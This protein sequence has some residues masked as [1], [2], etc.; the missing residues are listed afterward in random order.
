M[1]CRA[2]ASPR[3]VVAGLLLGW[4]GLLAA[5]PAAADER[6][7]AYDIAIEV[8]ADG[9]LDV[10][11]QITVRAEGNRVRRGIY[12]DFPTRYRDR[13]GNRVVVG[14][15][16]LDVR[17]NGAPEPHFTES[18]ANGIR[19][20]TGNDSFLPVPA[21]YT[22]TLRYRTTRQLGFFRDHDELYWNAIGTGWIFPIDQGRVTV[23]LPTAVPVGEMRAEGYTGPQGAQGRAYTADLPEAGMAR[24]R[25]TSRLAP[26]EGLTI[27]LSF[28]KGIVAE[29]GRG[30]RFWWLLA[31]NRGL[32]VALAGFVGL[33]AF[34]V[35]RWRQVG[36]DPR[37]GVIIPR[38][39]PP[40]GHGPAGLRFVRRM[41]YD[42][43]CFSADVL[44]M[45]VAGHLRIHHDDG[46][47]SDGWGLERA[48]A[49]SSPPTDPGQRKLLEGLFPGGVTRIELRKANATTIS[50]ARRAHDSALEEAAQ[51]RYFRRNAGHVVIA[52]LI[53]VATAL[54]AFFLSGGAGIAAIIV[55]L[56]AMVATII[57]FGRLVR[58]PTKEGRALLDE[59]EGLKLYLSVAER[60]ELERLP[61]PGA[62]PAL[63]AKRY[64][65]LLPYAVALEVEEAWTAKFTAAVGAAAAAAATGS[66]AW[67]RGS[68]ASNLGQLSQAVGSSLSSQIASSSTP[69]GSSRGGGGG[70]SSGGGG[71][72]GGGGGR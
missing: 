61:G 26:N 27:V 16:L 25:L 22:F 70:G 46:W 41:G 53:A 7:R 58:A 51:P 28:P 55:V 68:G 19:I 54:L 43:R 42:D 6:I 30:Q 32:L 67:Y 39:E 57:V 69:P 3:G 20:N 14:F 8:K 24:W 35:R 33:L 4:A 21:E 50:G 52:V 65:A 37:G 5:H 48:G 38:Y 59:I 62:P 49:R 64:E 63:D 71:G 13:Y 36:R 15:E 23:R 34:C 72:G 17:R 40:E 56:V 66:I 12:R 29:P 60:D 44:A 18:V 10:T 9:S 1:R 11:E 45:A 31:D 2:L 47:L